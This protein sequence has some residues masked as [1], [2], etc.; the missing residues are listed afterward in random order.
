M[1]KPNDYTTEVKLM[2]RQPT[3]I[4]DVI[5]SLFPEF[6]GLCY[7][8]EKELKSKDIRIASFY[9]DFF[10]GVL[11]VTDVQKAIEVGEYTKKE[12]E[13]YYLNV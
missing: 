10:H 8:H 5:N 3:V 6:K 11:Q 13:E 4:I 12:I 1:F 2:S 7:Y 9:F